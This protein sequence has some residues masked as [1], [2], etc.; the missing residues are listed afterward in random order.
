MQVQVQVQVPVVD[1]E[2]Q[3]VSR[4]RE[5]MSSPPDHTRFYSEN[6]K[7]FH[8]WMNIEH[9]AHLATEV[10]IPLAAEIEDAA[11]LANILSWD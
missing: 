4:G 5:S 7:A 8:S 11:I 6:C 3:V 1:A 9:A 2:G 10:L